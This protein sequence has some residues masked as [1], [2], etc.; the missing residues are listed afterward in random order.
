MPPQLTPKQE[1]FCQEYLI[2]LNAT[3]S[4]IRA[5]Y[6]A[7]S[8]DVRGSENLRNPH[9]Q[10]RIEELQEQRQERTQIKQDDVAQERGL[11]ALSNIADFLTI[12]NEEV[13]LKNFSKIDRKKLGAIQS[14]KK[15]RDG[16][17]TLSLHSK[18]SALAELAQIMG[19]K[20]DLNLAIA[21]FA[22]YGIDVKRNEDGTW[23]IP[24]SGD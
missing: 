18:M 1:R 23:F 21:S 24:N 10:S 20:T 3:Q 15:G 22:K 7:R 4:A 9:I 2:D 11:I 6:S 14:I 12:E 8:A 19:L 13:K 16:S 5:G 17:I